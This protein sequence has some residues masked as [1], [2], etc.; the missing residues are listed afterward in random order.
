MSYSMNNLAGFLQIGPHYFP[1]RPDGAQIIMRGPHGQ[2]LA[3]DPVHTREGKTRGSGFRWWTEE[4]Y[5]PPNVKWNPQQVVTGVMGL[6]ALG[7]IQEATS[8]QKAA[9]SSEAKNTLREAN[10]CVQGSCHFFVAKAKGLRSALRGFRKWE[11]PGVYERAAALLTVPT[12]LY[13]WRDITNSRGYD[14]WHSIDVTL[15]AAEVAASRRAQGKPVPKGATTPA[16]TPGDVGWGSVPGYIAD[17]GKRGEGGECHP[18]DFVCQAKENWWKIGLVGLGVL[19][20]Y[21]FASGY[22]RGLASR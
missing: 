5:V 15:Q 10:T 4:L 16:P 2:R 6:G 14:D 7:E 11:S 19:A 12:A 8:Q 3:A 17:A 22:G 13:Y 18:Y 20:L 9:L 21:G 1:D